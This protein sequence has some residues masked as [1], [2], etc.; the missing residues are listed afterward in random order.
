MKNRD[1]SL[2]GLPAPAGGNPWPDSPW[3]LIRKARAGSAEDKRTLQER[4]FQ[5]YYKPV[6]RFFQKV[7]GLHEERLKDVTQDFFTRFVE[8]DFL[9]N[10]THEKSFRNFLKVA[11]RRHYINWIDAER[12]RKAPGGRKVQSLHDEEGGMIDVPMPE[13]RTS[14]LLDEELRSQYLGEALR[15]VQERLMTD[16]KEVYWRVFEART[17]FD[18][19]K[20]TDYATIARE[21]G[22]S[23]FDVRNYLTAARKIFREALVELASEGAGDAKSELRE[24]G[25]EPLL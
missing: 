14:A 24:L 8:K 5:L 9:K 3:S 12:V 23:V 2:R 18:D 15:R 6:Y 4:L 17:R 1:S 13:E 21:V 11:C 20:P 7:L 22:R 25:L 19:E 10:V 16:G